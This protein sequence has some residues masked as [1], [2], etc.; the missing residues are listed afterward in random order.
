M[1]YDTV[2]HESDFV[3]N[4]CGYFNV[5]AGK[6]IIKMMIKHKIE[7]VISLQFGINTLRNADNSGIKTL[8]INDENINMKKVISFININKF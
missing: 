8:T 4:I 5:N 1:I 7:M 3:R 2:S 6:S